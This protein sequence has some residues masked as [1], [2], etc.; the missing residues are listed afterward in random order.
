MDQLADTLETNQQITN[1]TDLTKVVKDFSK[2]LDSEKLPTE[3]PNAFSE[4]LG[5]LTRAKS[6]LPRELNE[7]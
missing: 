5:L 2:L 4:A 6:D 3:D 1:E 7:S